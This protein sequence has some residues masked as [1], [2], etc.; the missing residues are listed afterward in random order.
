MTEKLFVYGIFLDERHRR[1]MGM[2]NPRYATVMD[3]VTFGNRVVQAFYM[4]NTKKDGRWGCSLTGL[5]LD[6]NPSYWGRLDALERGYERIRI[7]TTSGVE[8]WMYVGK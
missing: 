6:I 5:L 1:S 4:P 7:K 8:A 2:S 3:Y